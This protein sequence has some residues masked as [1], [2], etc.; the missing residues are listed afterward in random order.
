[1]LI[2]KWFRSKNGY[3]LVCKGTVRIDKEN[4]GWLAGHVLSQGRLRANLY[5]RRSHVTGGFAMKRFGTL[6][7]RS[8]TSLGSIQLEEPFRNR[9]PA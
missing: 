7:S 8:S 5:L 3:A 4:V 1:M 2:G 9:G 6:F